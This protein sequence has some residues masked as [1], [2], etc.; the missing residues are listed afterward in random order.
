LDLHEAIND[1][2]VEGVAFT[3]VADDC[4][5]PRRSLACAESARSPILT[6]R[7]NAD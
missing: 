6:A 1:V 4:A 5:A 2:P 3:G 7:I